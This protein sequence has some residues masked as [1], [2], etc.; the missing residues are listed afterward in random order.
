MR[1]T[2]EVTLDNDDV[3]GVEATVAEATR[4]A[5]ASLYAPAGSWE[6]RP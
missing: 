2:V 6:D 3:S 4:R 5:L 1:R